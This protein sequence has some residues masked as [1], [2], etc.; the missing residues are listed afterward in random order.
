M[1]RILLCLSIALVCPGPT[2]AQHGEVPAASQPSLKAPGFGTPV[3]VEPLRAT[4]PEMVVPGASARGRDPRRVMYPSK[5]S[6]FDHVAHRA[7]GESTRCLTCHGAALTGAHASSMSPKGAP[8]PALQAQVKFDHSLHHRQGIAC[9]RCHGGIDGT[10]ARPAGVGPDH[11]PDMS[12]CLG[13]HEDWASDR[14]AFQCG[15]CHLTDPGG[16]VLTDLPSG[17]FVPVGRYGYGDH[18]LGFDTGH[19]PLALAHPDRCETCHAPARCQ[20]CHTGSIRPVSQHP[21]DY[22]MHHGP[23]ARR[24]DPECSTCH[25]VSI[26]CVG[27]HLRSGLGDATAGPLAYG[28]DG[29]ARGSYHSATF[30][31]RPGDPPGPDHHRHEARRNLDA[32]VSCHSEQSCMRCHS[33]GAPSG[34]RASP[35]ADTA[36][37]C[38]GPWRLNPTGCLKCH[39]DAAGLERLCP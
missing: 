36:N 11:L 33:T 28:A 32:C 4:A 15:R 5:A 6:S 22:L 35:H 16:R 34:L 26:D 21:A 10:S 38:A 8:N 24:N 30:V 37:L 29:V 2:Y 39:T 18:R 3:I 20:T 17:Q 27:C 31:G 19:G 13:C 25:R 12:L 14:V 7:G 9:A 23:D 1:N